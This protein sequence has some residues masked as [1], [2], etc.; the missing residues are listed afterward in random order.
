MRGILATMRR[1]YNNGSPST[2]PTKVARIE[3]EATIAA[4]IDL[5]VRQ[6]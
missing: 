1:R 6:R 2:L 4:L 5:C 3:Q